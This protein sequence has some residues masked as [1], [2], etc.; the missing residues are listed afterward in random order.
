MDEKVLDD[1]LLFLLDAVPVMEL[2]Q[3]FDPGIDP[4]LFH[5][6]LLVELNHLLHELHCSNV[7]KL[8][9]VVIFLVSVLHLIE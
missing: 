7:L 8:E 6:D 3:Q 2:V 4:S 9:F 1:R 5:F